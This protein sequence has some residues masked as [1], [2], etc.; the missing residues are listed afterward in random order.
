MSQGGF[1]RVFVLQGAWIGLIGTALGTL[2]GLALSFIIERY[3]IIRIP[4]EV[5]GVAHLPVSLRISDVLMIIG[6]SV[7][8]SFLA[9]LYPA[10]QASGLEPVDAIRHE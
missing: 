9:T 2:G 1:L 7:A 6:G 10:M 4:A 3:E 5:Y 8:I